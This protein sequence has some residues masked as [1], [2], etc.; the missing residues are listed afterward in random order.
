MRKAYIT[1]HDPDGEHTV[2]VRFSDWIAWEKHTGKSAANGI[3]QLTDIAWLAWTASKRDGEKRPFDGF[4]A[5]VEGFP[6]AAF[7]GAEDPTQPEASTE[8]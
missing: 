2:E 7:E 8:R 3:E 5:R 1:W 4:V 6:T